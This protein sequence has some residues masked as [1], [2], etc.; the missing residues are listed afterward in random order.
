MMFSLLNIRNPRSYKPSKGFSIV[1]LDKNNKLPVDIG[2]QDINLVM[3]NMNVFSD[4]K[5]TP[6]DQT[7]GAVNMYE[8]EFKSNV[9]IFKNDILNIEFPLTV[10]LTENIRCITPQ[11]KAG[12]PLTDKPLINSI[13]C[14]AN[15]QILQVHLNGLEKEIGLFKFFIEGVK[16]PPSLKQSAPFVQIFMTTDTFYNI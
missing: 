6:A 1:T 7:N 8:V 16:N 10:Q 4:F 9:F 15:R 5:I 3:N 11:E 14:N 13:Q 2:G 12:K